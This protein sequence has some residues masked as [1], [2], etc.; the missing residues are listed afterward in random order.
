MSSQYN[1]EKLVG[2]GSYGN[3]YKVRDKTTCKVYAMKKV[4]IVNVSHYEKLNIVNELKIL[5]SH[6]CPFIVKF[7]NA[8]VD[9]SFIYFVTEFAGN[10]EPDIAGHRSF[11][12]CFIKRKIC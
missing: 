11:G 5:A 3:V 4:N 10:G 8:F 12:N 2:I 1:L 9:T 6:K 7:K